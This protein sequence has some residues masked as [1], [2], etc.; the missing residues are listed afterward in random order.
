[1]L[2]AATILTVFAV[3]GIAEVPDKTMVAMLLMG[4]RGYPLFVWLGAVAAFWVHVAIAVLAGQ[5]L[6][7]LP[8]KV[9]EIVIL[10]IFTAGAAYLLV[11]PERT[12]EERGARE[13]RRG[14]LSPHWAVAISAFFVILVSEFGDLTQ[15]L[16]VNFV[17]KTHSPWSVAIGAAGAFVVIAAVGAFAG[18]ALLRVLP[19]AII[20]R[21]G[22]LV[23]A[24]FAIAS[25]VSL[26]TG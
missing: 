6:Y 23:L 17:A 15:L 2:N 4:A 7:H 5:L 10:A 25:A 16:T 24:G 3:I 8:H 18:K 21:G 9:L 11:V 1:M 20:R 22:G 26:A 14:R 12:E 19:I 13:A